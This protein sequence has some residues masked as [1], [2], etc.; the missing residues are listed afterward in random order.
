M[1]RT[2]LLILGLLFLAL[3]V[4]CFFYSGHSSNMLIALLVELVFFIR[5]AMVKESRMSVK[6]PE[7]ITNSQ[8]LQQRDKE[9]EVA[10]KETEIQEVHP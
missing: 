4:T 8:P 6:T 9:Y 3:C 2:P 5:F 7:S 10:I 1:R